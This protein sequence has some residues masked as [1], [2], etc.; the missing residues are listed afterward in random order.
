M[1]NYGLC[2]QCGKEGHSRERRLNGNDVC[3]NGHTYPS[4]TAVPIRTSTVEDE[5]SATYA[6][7]SVEDWDGY[8]ACAI[9]AK[10]VE[11][12]KLFVNNFP[13]FFKNRTVAVVPE[14]DGNIAIEIY[15]KDD[16]TVLSFNFNDNPLHVPLYVLPTNRAG[17]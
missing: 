14:N 4:S 12:A 11:N 6:D 8:G 13:E 10:A 5:L 7:C 15:N 16:S 9:S 2:P 17:K 1:S 3:V